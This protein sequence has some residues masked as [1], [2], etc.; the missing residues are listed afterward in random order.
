MNWWKSQILELDYVIKQLLGFLIIIYFNLCLC[1][2][3]Q[4]KMI[5]KLSLD[6]DLLMQ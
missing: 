4:S 3:Q 1:L 2:F 6:I 5:I